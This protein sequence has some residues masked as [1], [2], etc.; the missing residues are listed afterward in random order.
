MKRRRAVVPGAVLALAFVMLSACAVVAAPGIPPSVPSVPSGTE[1]AGIAWTPVESDTAN[2]WACSTIARTPAYEPDYFVAEGG[3]DRHDGRDRARPFATLQRA[4]DVAQA[5]EVVWVR[6]GGYDAQVTFEGRGR[7]DAPIVFE[8]H[9]GECAVLDGARSESRSAVR[10][11]DARHYLF[12]HFVVRNST[13]QGIL[14]LR[15]HDNVLSDLHVHH[16]RLSG[17]QSVAGDR[18][19]FTRFVTHDN[20]DPPYG[21]DA[22]GIG[23]S[24]GSDN[25]IDR[26]VAF[27]NSDDGVDAWRSFGTVITRCVAFENGLQGGDGNGFKAGGAVANRTVLR[28]NLSFGNVGHGFTYNLGTQVTFEHNTAYGNGGYGFVAGRARLRNNLA[29]GDVQGPFFDAGS[30]ETAGNSWSLGIADPRFADTRPSSAAFL[31]LRPDSPAIDAGT[32]I[33]L[34]FAGAAPDLGAVPFGD[35]LGTVVGTRLDGHPARREAPHRPPDRRRASNATGAY[36]ITNA[37]IR[38]AGSTGSAALA[39]HAATEASA[40][41]R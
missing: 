20:Y 21:E 9:P 10:F 3:D 15:S 1:T 24:S 16:N 13:T 26:C 35:T 39:P 25:R 38:T 11:V 7:P 29:F 23:I 32:T 6:G 19:R 27:R 30:N 31:S 12:R 22:D 33:G 34:P 2:G 37:A 40:A 14:L 8:S 4:A 5:G 28:S 17:I 18:N 41:P 36:T